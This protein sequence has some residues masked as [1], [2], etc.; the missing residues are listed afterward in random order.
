MDGW[1]EARRGRT[2]DEVHGPGPQQGGH[3]EAPAGP[4]V[5]RRPAR[6]VHVRGAGSASLNAPCPSGGVQQERRQQA[7]ARLSARL[8]ERMVGGEVVHG[9]V[10]DGAGGGR[11]GGGGGRGGKGAKKKSGVPPAGLTTGEIWRGRDGDYTMAGS[12]RKGGRG[13]VCGCEQDRHF[14]ERGVRTRRAAP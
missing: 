4:S 12:C 14:A 9:E 10:T 6:G 11:G 7:R 5:A 3:S 13:G 8:L 2:T 1:S